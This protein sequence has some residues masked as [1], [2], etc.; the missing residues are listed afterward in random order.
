MIKV[1]SKNSANQDLYII[2]LETKFTI[3]RDAKCNISFPGNK[4][5]SKVHSTIFYDEDINSWKIIDGNLEKN[6]TNGVW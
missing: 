3:G 5:Y 6:S 1:D 4:S 2:D